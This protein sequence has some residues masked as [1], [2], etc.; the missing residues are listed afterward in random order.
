[1]I[2]LQTVAVAFAMFSAV[3]V[4]QFNWT[5]KNMR[6]AMCAFPLIGVVIGLLWFL[7]G[8]L[9]LP[10][11][12]RAAGFCLIP[13]WVT[14]GI[15][16]DG[17][18]DTCDALSSYGDRE[19]KLEILEDPHCGAF[20]VIR[21]CSYFAAYLALCRE[22]KKRTDEDLQNNVIARFHDESQLNR[23]VAETPGKFRILP[24]D[25]CTP[26]ETPTGHEAIL[27]LQKSR[28]INVESVKGAAKPQNFFQR[29]WEAF[30]LNWL[31]YLWLARDTLLRRRI[32]FKNDL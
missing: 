7:C 12:A 11:A 26:E 23:L 14:G 22:L 8:V 3:P 16:L 15:H 18:A 6:Y 19:K 21:L 24:P 20:A 4:P 31:P 17:Y 32:D 5:E 2:V 27:V 9:P 30:R 13:V 10:G 29:K 25:Y 1:M 28:C